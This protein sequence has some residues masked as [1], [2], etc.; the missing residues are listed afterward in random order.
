MYKEEMEMKRLFLV[1]AAIALLSLC[2]IAQAD[3]SV[4]ASF[5]IDQYTLTFARP[6]AGLSGPHNVGL[7]G[8]MTA[9]EFT[10]QI[11]AQAGPRT[12]TVNLADYQQVRHV[13]GATGSS[14]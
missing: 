1:V 4:T 10:A 8:G 7:L 6:I 9:V 12:E 5:A 2:A 13:S 3:I 11:T 14:M